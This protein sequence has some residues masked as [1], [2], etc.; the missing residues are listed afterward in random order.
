[1][2]T[3]DIADCESKHMSGSNLKNIFIGLLTKT[4]K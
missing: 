4:Y 3:C 1:V 2:G